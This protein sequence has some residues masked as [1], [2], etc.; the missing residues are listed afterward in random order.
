MQEI[1]FHCH[2]D[3]ESFDASRVEAVTECFDAGFSA[4]VTVA[5]PYEKESQSRSLEA[6]DA[7]PRVFLMAAAHPH[8]A[9]QYSPEVEQ[10]LERMLNHPKTI[11]LGEAGLDFHYD[12]SLRENQ[13]RV[14][15]RQV[16]L[17][18][19]R[20]LPLVIHSRNAEMLVLDTLERL[21]FPGHVVFHC[22][23]GGAE[24]AAEIIRRGYDLSFSGIITFRNAAAL[25]K[26]ARRTPMG[27][28]FTETDSPYLSPEPFRGRANR[29]LRVQQVVSS[30]AQLHEVKAEAVTNAVA[31][32]LE[33]CFHIPRRS[34]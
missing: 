6:L 23:T 18:A 22:F 10:R 21:Q 25:R 14:F 33:E 3:S 31:R 9:D 24:A 17:A 28:F 8:N 12:L 34:T 11:G 30:L 27:R 4:L 2:L 32:R 26:I 29:P 16:A 7:H 19:E 20:N 5:D 13:Q 1:D 15:E